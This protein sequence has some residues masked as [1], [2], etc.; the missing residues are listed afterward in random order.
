MRENALK[1]VE[2]LRENKLHIA[3]AES[4]TGGLIAAAITDIPGSSEVF[5]CGV[6]SY[7]EDIKNSVLGVS[8]NVLEKNGAVSFA[9]ASMMAQGVA[10]VAK[11]EI[12]VSATGYAGPGGGTENDPVGT[13]YIGVYLKNNG[14]TSFSKSFR[15]VFEGDR[16][17]VRNAAV[18]QAFAEICKLL[19]I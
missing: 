11:A 10:S 14:H 1:I 16:E 5:D 6:V 15:Y 12:G 18:E 8:K 9:C 13:V 7:G 17:A 19:Y 2:Y 3:T 4:C